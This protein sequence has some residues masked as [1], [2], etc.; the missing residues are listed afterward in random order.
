ML[1]TA[2]TAVLLM[3]GTPMLLTAEPWGPPRGR[4]CYFPETVMYPSPG[5][6]IPI[7]G[8]LD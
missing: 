6:R 4:P 8:P 3:S 5:L 1:L 7:R 2:E